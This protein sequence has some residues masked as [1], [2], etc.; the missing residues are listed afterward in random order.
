MV[1]ST[2]ESK[3]AGLRLNDDWRK[4]MDDGCGKMCACRY[5]VVVVGA[6]ARCAQARKISDQG[7]HCS[8]RVLQRHLNVILS[9]SSCGLHGM[10]GAG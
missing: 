2:L 9:S 4:T 7:V 8:Q 10:V 3:L 1:L 5:V 6:H